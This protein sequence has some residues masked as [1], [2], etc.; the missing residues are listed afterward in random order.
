MERRGIM[1]KVVLIMTAVFVL[2]ITA[3]AA[4]EGGKG[5]K[6]MT[7]E[8]MIRLAESAAPHRISWDAAILVPGEGGAWVEARQ[9]TNGFTCLPDLSAQEEADPICGDAAATMWVMDLL[10]GKERPSNTVPGIAYM[11]KGGWHWEKDGLVIMDMKA[12]GAK[13][14][15]EPPHWMILWPFDPKA[16]MLPVIP[17]KFGAYV[18]YEGTP[19]SHLMIYQDPNQMG[20]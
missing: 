17:G 18:M 1:K 11:A 2:S 9:G 13:R 5:A 8:D 6:S 19:Y 12:P 7:K 16:A 10:G 4:A 15:K 14:V 3:H 20:K